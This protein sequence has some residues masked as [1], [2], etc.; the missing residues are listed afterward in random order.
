M[1]EWNKW[2]RMNENSFN[3]KGSKEKFR[4]TTCNNSLVDKAQKSREIDNKALWRVPTRKT[5]RSCMYVGVKEWY[6][7][8]PKAGKE[9]PPCLTLTAREIWAVLRQLKNSQMG[10]RNNC[11]LRLNHAY[12]IMFSTKHFCQFIN[13]LWHLFFFLNHC[14]KSKKG[15]KMWSKS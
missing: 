5:W 1:N 2:D 15:S 10:R 13:S 3:G 9:M 7:L 4:L 6:G 12:Q 14:E 8:Q 11:L